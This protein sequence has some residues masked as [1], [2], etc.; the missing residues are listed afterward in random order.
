M[1]AFLESLDASLADADTGRR[2]RPAK[3]IS[4]EWPPSCP[5]GLCGTQ[6][7]TCRVVSRRAADDY[8][9]CVNEIYGIGPSE[10]STTLSSDGDLLNEIAEQVAVCEVVP[11]EE[12]TPVK[13]KRGRPC[14]KA[15][16]TLEPLRLSDLWPQQRTCEPPPKAARL[17]LVA[18]VE[19]STDM[20]LE[21]F[22]N[23]VENR[24]PSSRVVEAPGYVDLLC[25]EPPIN[26][27]V[28][29]TGLPERPPEFL[30]GVRRHLSYAWKPST[31]VRILKGSYDFL[32]S[33]VDTK[34]KSLRTAANVRW[35]T[36]A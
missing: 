27:R 10:S 31:H 4:K 20:L 1:D 35:M 3:R 14:K 29:F 15:E 5:T 26:K 9:D 25:H 19:S 34:V 7:C 32:P 17:D 8:W 13:R 2:R 21:L 6:G 18:T 23:P 28:I 12:A 30:P 16:N 24:I 33:S 36:H 11:A 22:D